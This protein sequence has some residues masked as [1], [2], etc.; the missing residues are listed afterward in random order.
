MYAIRSYYA[1]WKINDKNGGFQYNTKYKKQETP[2]GMVPVEGGTFTMGKVE[3]DPMH[4]WNNTPSQQHVQSFFMDETEVTN[5]M[6]TE[7]LF[8]LK[9]V[10]P[11]AEEN[12][13]NIY[14]G[15]ITS[16]SIHYTKLYEARPSPT[17]C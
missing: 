14:A 1:G 13:K 7:Y 4:D 10:F 6:Y 5:L 12:Y 11:P 15:V 16:Y 9:T 2:P 8:W 3:D 17:P